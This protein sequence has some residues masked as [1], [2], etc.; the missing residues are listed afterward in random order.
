MCIKMLP[1]STVCCQLP[2]QSNVQS[3]ERVKIFPQ[4]IFALKVG[5]R[6]APGDSGKNK[7]KNQNSKLG[8]PVKTVSWQGCDSYTQGIFFVKS[9]L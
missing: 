1:T 6:G 2:V 9:A 7:N 4:K 5:L 8:V 3:T